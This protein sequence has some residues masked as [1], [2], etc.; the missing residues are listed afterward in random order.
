MENSLSYGKANEHINQIKDDCGRD[1]LLPGSALGAE[2]VSGEDEF[3]RCQHA[4]LQELALFQGTLHAGSNT[5][6]RL[7][8][9]VFS[10]LEALH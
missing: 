4:L 6:G 8:N 7:V 1:Y 9:T 2:M 10:F 5:G 3:L